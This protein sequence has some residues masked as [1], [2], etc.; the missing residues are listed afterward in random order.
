MSAAASAWR[1]FLVQVDDEE[2][3]EDVLVA[4]ETFLFTKAKLTSPARAKGLGL[5]AFQKNSDWPEELPVQAFLSRVVMALDAAAAADR[6]AREMAS[7]NR[8]AAGSMSSALSL[9]SALAPPRT[10]DVPA[11]LASANL[12]KLPFVHQLDQSIVD[13]MN[14]ETQEAKIL[15]RHPFTY[16]DLT[17]K[18]VVPV[19]LH[20]EAVGGRITE[21]DAELDGMMQVN[22][23]AKLGAALRSATEGTRFFRTLAQWS[24][25]YWRW[26]P[27][28][29]ALGHLSWVQALAH[30]DT[31]CAIVEEEKEE[32]KGPYLAFLY[33]DMLRRQLEKRFQKKKRPRPRC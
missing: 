18:E 24:A 26:V 6:T 8:G 21:D 17:A 20:P 14:G 12:S 31:I 23:L 9:A 19:W 22:S 11:V 13:K 28:A 30:N 10:C 15:S 25:S 4:A 7:T 32:G 3:E 29:V 27:M 5:E 16:V 33:D 1:D 2:P